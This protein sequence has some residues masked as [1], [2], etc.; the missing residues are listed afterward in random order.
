MKRLWMTVAMLLLFVPTMA[1]AAGVSVSWGDACWSDAGAA[2]NL[3]WACD[4]NTNDGIRMTCSFK[5]DAGTSDFVGVCV[6]MEGS[7]GDWLGGTP[8]PDWWK[9]GEATSGDCRMNL[10]TVSAAGSFSTACTNPWQGEQGG[11]IGL[12]S[13]QDGGRMHVNAAWAM[14]DPVKLEAGVEYFAL[15]FRISA[16]KTVG[17]CAGCSVPVIWGLNYMEIALQQQAQFLH[18]DRDYSGGNQCL[19][20]QSSTQVCTNPVPARNTTWGQIKTLYR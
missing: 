20:W 4:S 6:F 5:L 12:Y 19:T 14:A 3:T 9:L 2:S 18:L 10:I 15:Q 13:W 16:A 11:G 7:A 8:V 17:A 1:M